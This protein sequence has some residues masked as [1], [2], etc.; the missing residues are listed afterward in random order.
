MAD[1]VK[2][3]KRCVSGYSLIPDK[4]GDYPL[5]MEYQLRPLKL[6]FLQKLFDE[7]P[8][9]P[10]AGNADLIDCYRINEE[11]AKALQPYVIDGVIDL[12]KYIFQL[13]CYAD[14]QM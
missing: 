1:D 9:D 6:S 3:L 11:Q 10:D 5:K 8:N 4:D 12:E 2:G 7:D 13:E 14:D